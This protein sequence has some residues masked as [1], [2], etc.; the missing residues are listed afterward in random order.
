MEISAIPHIE[1]RFL[2]KEHRNSK[3][4][5]YKRDIIFKSSER[6]HKKFLMK[7]NKMWDRKEIFITQVLAPPGP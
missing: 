2:E 5:I 6:T 1:Q 7:G 3:T 4:T